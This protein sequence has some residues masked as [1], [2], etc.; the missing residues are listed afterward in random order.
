MVNIVHEVLDDEKEDNVHLYI[1]S[2][3]N[4]QSLS[5]ECEDTNE[6]LRYS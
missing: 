3:N 1:L 6:S 2:D 5:S 4:R